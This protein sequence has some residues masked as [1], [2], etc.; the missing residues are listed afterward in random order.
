MIDDQVAR[1][2]VE[3]SARILHVR[4]IGGR[5]AHEGRLR[6]VLGLRRPGPELRPHVTAKA[7]PVNE[8]QVG[9]LLP[10]LAVDRRAGFEQ[11]DQ[12]LGERVG[13][14]DPG[15]KIVT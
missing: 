2:G 14:D 8:I 15:W 5:E 13:H 6:D 4:R 11:M 7:L 12:A 10:A 1:G 3:K 9:E